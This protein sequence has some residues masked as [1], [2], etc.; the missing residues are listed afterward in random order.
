MTHTFLLNATVNISRGRAES[1]SA[2][3]QPRAGGTPPTEGKPTLGARAGTR[4]LEWELG[5]NSHGEYNRSETNH[6]QINREAN[7]STER[8]ALLLT[9]ATPGPAPPR[10]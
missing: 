4:T 10:S 7:D 6:T 8:Y 2:P 3:W 9:E 5:I 1:F